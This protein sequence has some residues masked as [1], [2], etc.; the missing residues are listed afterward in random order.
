MRW[1][2]IYEYEVPGGT[3]NLSYTK[4]PRPWTSWKSPP[5][6]ENLHGR[7][8][9]RTWDLIISSLKLWPLDHVVS[10]GCSSTSFYSPH[11]LVLCRLGG[12]A[13]IPSEP[14]ENHHNYRENAV[15]TGTA[16]ENISLYMLWKT[17]INGEYP[18]CV[19]VENHTLSP[20]RAALK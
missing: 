18:L 4:L 10:K 12:R 15:H 8:G 20:C 17:W 14:T 5:S 11:F 7:T 1:M 6:R 2:V 9:N 3:L 19:F 16:F 13:Q